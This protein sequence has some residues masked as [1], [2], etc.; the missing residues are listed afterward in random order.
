VNILE[1]GISKFGRWSK[2]ISSLNM[3]LAPG[4]LL[5]QGWH[6]IDERTWRYGSYINRIEGEISD[7]AEQ[8]GGFIA[9]RS[10]S[11]S[12]TRTGL[13][14]QVIPYASKQDAEDSIPQDLTR[15]KGNM[16]FKGTI[17]DERTVDGLT[18]PSVQHVRFFEQSV[19]LGE[20]SSLT[21]CVTGNVDY[22]V[23]TVVVTESDETLGWDRVL[24]V[25]NSLADKIAKNVT[26]N[27]DA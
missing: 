27:R 25:A 11:K 9:W 13:W 8:A 7:R 6:V 2:R 22:I 20:R 24:T 4:E 5:G 1:V 14:E 19:S 26:K 21:R 10:F 12:K 17:V 23:F 3:L 15:F 18:L 16:R